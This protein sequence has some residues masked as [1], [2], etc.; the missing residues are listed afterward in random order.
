MM[1]A[2]R[3]VVGVVFACGLV[4]GGLVS[5]P[6]PVS[7]ERTVVDIE[8]GVS[9]TA[10]AP[11]SSALA[12]GVGYGNGFEMS[13]TVTGKVFVAGHAT[14][15]EVGV[16]RFDADGVADPSFGDDGSVT[17]DSAPGNEYV[18]DVA[19]LA[20]GGVLV[21]VESVSGFA[22][23]S[24]EFRLVHLREDGSLD[25]GYGTGGVFILPTSPGGWSL[26]VNE[27]AVGADGSVVLSAY[28]PPIPSGAPVPGSDIGLIG[29]GAAPSSAASVGPWRGVAKV[30]VA[31]VMAEFGVDGWY[32]IPD[33]STD[34]A[35]SVEIDALQRVWVLTNDTGTMRKL[36]PLGLLETSF[37]VTP[38][39]GYYSYL[40]NNFYLSQFGGGVV[41]WNPVY[42][43]D[44]TCLDVVFESYTA[45]GDPGVSDT[46]DL[47]CGQTI[48]N[49]LEVSAR[50]GVAY[51]LSETAAGRLVVRRV[52]RSGE[53]SDWFGIDG[54]AQIPS[55]F[56]TSNGN[57]RSTLT[58][59][60]LSRPLVA[61]VDTPPI[62]AASELRV[63]RF[64]GPSGEPLDLP[65]E[66]L[67]GGSRPAFWSILDPIDT[68]T[69]NLTGSWVDLTEPGFG[70]SLTRSYNG[71]SDQVSPMGARWLLSTG[72]SLLDGDGVV[73]VMLADGTRFAF[74]EDGSGGYIAPDGLAGVMT[75]D[76]APAS[77]GGSLPMLRVE[78]ANGAVDRFETTG[79]LLQQVWWD[80][81]QV[82]L[83]YDAAGLLQTVTSSNGTVLTFAYV[84]GRPVSVTSSTGRSVSYGYDAAGLLV[85]VTD[86][87]GA[88]STITYTVEGWL[89]TLTDPAGVVLED[90]TYDTLGRVIE[91]VQASGVVMSITYDDEGVTTMTDSGTGAVVSYH[92]DAS[93]R[94][95]EIIDPFNNRIEQLYDENSNLIGSVSRS[96]RE[97]QATYDDNYNLLSVTRP[98]SG[99]S[100]YTYDTQDRLLTATD[101]HGATTT[102]T[103]DGDERQATTTTDALGHTTTFN[104][105][106][107]LT[108][109][110]TDADG[111][112]TT[113]T[114]DPQR[115]M[116]STVNELGN[117]TSYVYDM[118]GRLA[119]T[120][121]PGGRTT[122]STYAPNGRM[123]SSSAPDGGV[124]AYTYDAAG[125]VL[126]VTDPTGAVTTS[127]YNALGQLV[128][129]TDPAGAV[130]S[131]E[132]DMNGRRVATVAPGGVRTETGYD[133]LA[134]AT[135][136][137][138]ALGDQAL[139]SFDVEGRPTS[140]TVASTGAAS[141]TEYDADG[142]VAAT[143]DAVGRRSENS[144]DAQGRLVATLAAGGAQT[145]YGF[146]VLGRQTTVT[147]ARGG[148]TTTTF[149]PGG[150]TATVTDPAGLVTSY[151]Y[152]AAGRTATATLPG[153]REIDT[154]YNAAGDVLSEST[155][156][157]LATTYTHDTAG[158][159]ATVTDPTGVVTTRTYDLRGAVLT[160][161]IGAQGVSSNVYN[162]TGTLA[163]V[164]DSLGNT[165]TFT[166]DGRGNTLTRTDALGGVETWTYNSA[167]QVTSATDPLG[168]V[169][170]A[171]YN[172]TGQLVE[173]TDSSGRTSTST[174]N[175]DGTI[176]ETVATDGTDTIP[177]VYAY[178]AAGR[179][180]SVGDG[181]FA[182][183][184]SYEYNVA[185]DLTYSS[186]T[187]ISYGYDVAGRRISMQHG[188]RGI[189]Y[190][191]NT[192]GEL[193]SITR[194]EEMVDEFALA[195]GS[196]PSATNWTRTAPVGT[197]ASN[198][199]GALLLTV[200]PTATGTAT[201]LVT[202]KVAARL[203][204]DVTFDYAWASPTAP[205]V[206]LIAYARY[207]TTGHYRIEIGAGA[208]IATLYKRIGTA[209]TTL[210]TVPVSAEAGQIRMR[211]VGD[212]ISVTIDDADDPVSFTSGGVTAPGTARLGLARVN[213]AGQ[214]SIG[215]WQQS[216]PTTPTV[217]AG[218]TY[219]FDGQL[220]VES[221]PGGNRTRTYTNGRMVGFNETVPGR[222]VATTLAYDTTGRIVTDT[223]G[224]LTTSYTYDLA[225]QLTSATPTTGSASTW[226]YD[227]LGR[228]RT[229]KIA[230]TTTKY[231]YDAGSQLCWSTTGTLA[232][233]A[234]CA[235][236]PVSA[237]KFVW[238]PAG[239]L[240]SETRTATNKVAYGYDVLGRM[241]NA[242]RVN[243]TTTTN[244]TREYSIEGLVSSINNETVTP[245]ATTNTGA[246]FDWDIAAGGVPQLAGLTNVTVTGYTENSLVYG[247]G[248]FAAVHATTLQPVA[249]AQDAHG[250]II[251]STGNTLARSATYNAYGT[252]TGT[253]TFEAR[254]GYRGELTVDNQLNLRARNYQSTI[255]MMTSRDPAPGQPGTTTLTNPYHYA[256]N[257]PL[258]RTDPTGQTDQA[259]TNGS[260]VGT[261][262][263]FGAESATGGATG[264]STSIPRQSFTP[265]PGWGV[266]VF[267][268]FIS[269]C[270][271]GGSFA[272][273][274]GN[275]RQFSPRGDCSESYKICLIVDFEAGW[276]EGSISSTC[277]PDGG[278]CKDALPLGEGNRA[279]LSVLQT[280]NGPRVE[281]EI[282]GLNPY[283]P[284][285]IPAIN[286]TIAFGSGVALEQTFG[287]R[288]DRLQWE[289]A[290]GYEFTSRSAFV[291]KAEGDD[292][293]SWEA[294]RLRDGTL[295]TLFQ[296]REEPPVLGVPGALFP[297]W[298]NRTASFAEFL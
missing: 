177:R 74:I 14:N 41:T 20:D 283:A 128:S 159:I 49:V 110:T 77:G 17:V 70:L 95:V 155:P 97:A 99:T 37:P 227:Q 130:T 164:T 165:T 108:M 272:P 228:R 287:P 46:L 288:S 224:T 144:Y 146:D 188:D 103:Y 120:T 206:K 114:Y 12:S 258:N 105:V 22:P 265:R 204:S 249:I 75:V 168:R 129:T 21:L 172:T 52:G 5:A 298:P 58:A 53:Q 39:N 254:L 230:A 267:N 138:T 276:V 282:V 233:N 104:I 125:K 209:T 123:V 173:S 225:S 174:Y 115:R 200:G 253:N 184:N 141:V 185:G 81:Q 294:Y 247:P 269:A 55:G 79:R 183:P 241:I 82:D 24:S 167:N 240:L 223:T 86:E 112:T 205:A 186:S 87:F 72:P 4:A 180:E 235:T 1:R 182:P 153:G 139:T 244:H 270:D 111:V 152:D 107:G 151:A 187:D 255:G 160:E 190:R 63:T 163:S 51:V 42:N 217:V 30:T 218:Y 92:H 69:G 140:R 135:S 154:V 246:F 260:P 80:G 296:K 166:Y 122:T 85:S 126:T 94:I 220:L 2:I 117:T 15:Y 61:F 199:S 263:A 47:G 78:Y 35:P 66:T 215:R 84:N 136:S 271:A 147:D 64:Q 286:L 8:F 212:T 248:G 45:S 175:L 134:R 208:T 116:T 89:K 250:S 268:A 132:Y 292:F 3:R 278:S 156:S 31:G 193:S 202:S 67:I 157:G 210:G 238:D 34:S 295:D 150:R 54:V 281:A 178:D 145:A 16:L 277:R 242:T 291:V 50:S 96:D 169:T 28:T 9:G 285:G 203:D 133:A 179:V 93:G 252:P 91:Q 289:P 27:M 131:F 60:H 88:T 26:S 10:T 243:G 102:Y 251:P 232:A 142:R 98:G 256:D 197:T 25:P 274:A 137:T 221:L 127:T 118:Q 192:A 59:D 297:I 194:S 56:N 171:T 90:N 36:S 121:S 23:Y 207:S 214:V 109:S 101:P 266:V 57:Y 106:N 18:L 13:A 38:N 162:P 237:A 73:E 176:A 229:E 29:D 262:T 62:P 261:S 189:N 124:T 19:A 211:V 158:R 181:G 290:Y 113:N 149:T 201:A 213:G 83:T 76:S 119:S 161:K 219:N 239:R 33:G 196:A 226:T 198:D 68:A 257:N 43:S 11:G 284:R 245:T 234:S 195:D 65:V 48:E 216:D 170:T 264:A 71:L 148:I 143:V 293:P 275:C 100:T 191:Y 40:P 44:T 222:T 231:V 32:E 273:S 259:A 236:A 280:S 6:L 279:D 7:A